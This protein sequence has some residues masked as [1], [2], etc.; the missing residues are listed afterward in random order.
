MLK[1]KCSMIDDEWDKRQ[2]ARQFKMEACPE[3]LAIL[4][5]DT[6]HDLLFMISNFVRLQSRLA[7]GVELVVLTCMKRAI[8]DV[9]T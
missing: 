4:S 6:A 3:V 8:D 1:E 7:Y 9:I 2:E 5:G